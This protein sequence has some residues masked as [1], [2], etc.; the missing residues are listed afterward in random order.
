MHWEL[1]LTCLL[2]W[3]K[4][5]REKMA[6]VTR[7]GWLPP[8]LEDSGSKHAVFAPLNLH[9]YLQQR[10]RVGQN[11]LG[12]QTCLSLASLPLSWLTTISGWLLESG[13]SL[14]LLWGL[15][16]QLTHILSLFFGNQILKLWQLA[17]TFLFLVT[18]FPRLCHPWDSLKLSAQPARL[19]WESQATDHH[20][21][22]PHCMLWVSA[23][24]TQVT[25]LLLGYSSE[26]TK[27]Q[28]EL[29]VYSPV[30]HCALGDIERDIENDLSLSPVSSN[31]CW[32]GNDSQLL[33]TWYVPG[34]KLIHWVFHWGKYF[35]CI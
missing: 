10:L 8:M 6:I 19:L 13:K 35:I 7:G 9:D 20:Q 24:C 27:S 31:F 3:G 32:L 11:H 23:A 21:S 15:K 26:V 25:L 17:M 2:G 18:A 4:H 1:N 30:L 22:R 29:S 28:W 5:Y 14:W 16:T 33:N 34:P 12:C